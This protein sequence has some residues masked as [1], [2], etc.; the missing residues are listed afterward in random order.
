LVGVVLLI[1]CINVANLL[2]ARAAARQREIAVRAALGAGRGLLIRQFLMENAVLG[3]AGGS[4]GLL[5]SSWMIRGLVRILPFDPANNSLSTSPDLR[6]LVFTGGIT[7]LTAFFFGVIP[8]FQ[9]SRV[10]P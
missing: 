7:L 10:S 4:T 5:L 8:A 2:L 1:A 6:I 9:G 3:V